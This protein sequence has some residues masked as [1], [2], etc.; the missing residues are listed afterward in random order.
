M[1][2]CAL[3]ITASRPSRRAIVSSVRLVAESRPAPRVL[4]E[5]LVVQAL[6]E[7][8]LIVAEALLH[9]ALGESASRAIPASASA[10]SRRP[11]RSGRATAAASATAKTAAMAM[12]MI[13]ACS[14]GGA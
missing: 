12:A 3:S 13:A 4:G 14:I 11:R 9:L 5:L 8:V 6:G 1:F 10:R 2:S 7:G